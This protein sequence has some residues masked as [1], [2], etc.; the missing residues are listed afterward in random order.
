MSLYA[1]KIVGDYLL[2]ETQNAR[3]C[4]HTNKLGHYYF[5]KT[6]TF[7][8]T[9]V[10][11]CEVVNEENSFCIIFECLKYLSHP[12]YII[13]ISSIQKLYNIEKQGNDQVNKRNTYI[14]KL[15][16]QSVVH[17]TIFICWK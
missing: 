7:P 5:N 9:H 16:D 3:T 2:N 17:S 6:T 10:V 15:R 4:Y 13:N 8:Y 11:S 1:L 14:E 12:K